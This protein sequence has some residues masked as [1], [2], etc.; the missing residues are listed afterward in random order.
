MRRARAEPVHTVQGTTGV[1][2]LAPT[3]KRSRER[4]A[5]ILGCAEELLLEKGSD[6]FR[7]S[8][9]VERAGVPFGSLYQY[10]PDKTAII[11]TLAERYNA[12]GHECVHKE[13]EAMRGAQDLH[14][15]LGRIT[16]GFYQMYRK[17]PV[18][19]AIWQATS[20]DRALQDLDKHDCEYLAG[21]LRD[22]LRPFADEDPAEIETFSKLTIVL[23]GAA[24]RYAITL[25]EPE[26]KR[27]LAQ[28]KG[29]LPDRPASGKP[30]APAPI[31]H[32]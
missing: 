21:L 17:E 26:A 9:I 19:A 18:M 24:V 1:A 27:L 13:L 5:K 32:D 29:M 11:G 20:A 28:F 4:F 6:A 7:M 16:D 15:A 8:D 12:I 25:D 3:Q 2:R 30:A 14:A 22:A 10:F 23:I 31:P